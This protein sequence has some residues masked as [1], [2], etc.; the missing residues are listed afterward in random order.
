MPV[1]ILLKFDQLIV[2]KCYF[3]VLFKDVL[4]LYFEI[5]SNLQENLR[6][7]QRTLTNFSISVCVIFKEPVENKLLTRY[8]IILNSAVC[9][10]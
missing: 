3:F 6:I 8:P 1:L 5:V 2:K 10:S 7:V 9:I 4:M